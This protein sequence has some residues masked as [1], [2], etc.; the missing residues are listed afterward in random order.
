MSVN[1]AYVR[2]L[3][4]TNGISFTVLFTQKVEVFCHLNYMHAENFHSQTKIRLHMHKLIHVQTLLCT[5]TDFCVES[6]TLT[7]F[8]L[9]QLFVSS[10]SRAPFK[11]HDFSQYNN[12][13]RMTAL[14]STSWSV[15]LSFFLICDVQFGEPAFQL[16]I[17]FCEGFDG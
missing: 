8:L 10:V 9:S 6:M 7:L 17:H 13:Q 16:S 2:D 12:H 14:Y 1:S 4:V 3:T 11:K 5:Y 15:S